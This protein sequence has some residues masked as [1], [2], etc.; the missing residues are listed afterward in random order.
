VISANFLD[1][2]AGKV[3][4]ALPAFVMGMILLVVMQKN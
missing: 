2:K 4:L 3:F 1:I